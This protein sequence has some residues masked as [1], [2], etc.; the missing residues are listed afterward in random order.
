MAVVVPAAAVWAGTSRWK[1]SSRAALVG[2]V[3][4]AVLAAGAVYAR[5]LE[6]D[7]TYTGS[8]LRSQFAAASV[9]VMQVRPW[10]GVGVGQYYYDS[11]LFLTPQLAWAYGSENAHNNFLQLAVET[12]V[13][14]FALL[15][16]LLAGAFQ[17]AAGAINRMP[18]DWRLLGTLAG[19]VAFLGTCLVGHPLLVADVAAA[20]WL[21]IGLAA[22][23]GSSSWLNRQAEGRSV[24]LQAD[25]VRPAQAGRYVVVTTALTLLLVVGPGLALRKPVAPVD[26][27][28]VS[29]FYGWETAADGVRFRWSHEYASLFVPADV[30]RVEIP[31]R[32]PMAGPL[33]E[34]VSIEVG[35][36]GTT[37]AR[38]FVTNQWQ[39]IAVDLQ[40]PVPPLEFGRINIKTNRLSRPILFT[41]GSADTR[42]VGVQVGEYRV[43][44]ATNEKRKTE[45]G[46]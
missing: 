3:L 40:R 29:G 35:A 26:S 24:R 11:P 33:T 2:A 22:A 25:E 15:A 10:F 16:L 32:A 28:W 46:K 31:V 5:Q 19:V 1:A 39:T 9:R 41:P 27:E 30:R 20:F 23:L 44:D 42:V 7:P 45:N 12:G 36:G 8:G 13:I 43:V 4:A 21:Q 18:R 37:L 14:G 6:R 38:A 17:F 34:P